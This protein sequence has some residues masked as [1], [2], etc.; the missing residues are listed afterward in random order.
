[1]PPTSEDICDIK[2]KL[3][4]EKPSI[5][6]SKYILKKDKNGKVENIPKTYESLVKLGKNVKDSK[7][8]N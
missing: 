3:K 1:M 6:K 8:Q 7:K 2:K 4:G 5:I